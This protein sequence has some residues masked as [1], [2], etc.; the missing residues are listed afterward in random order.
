MAHK[1]RYTVALPR[2]FD[3]IIDD[4]SDQA[5]ATKGEIIRRA[6]ALYDYIHKQVD[7]GSTVILKD[8]NDHEK[9]IVF[10]E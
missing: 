8:A 4:L 9:E 3:K 10:T 6:V 7:Q 5:G 2:K 1:V